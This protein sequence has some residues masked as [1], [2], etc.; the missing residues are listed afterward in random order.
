MR[1]TPRRI[2][3]IPTVR[4]QE[5]RKWTGCLAFFSALAILA[6]ACSDDESAPPEEE[7]C[8]RMEECISPFLQ[9]SVEDCEERIGRCVTVQSPPSREKFE[10]SVRFCLESSDCAG[11]NRCYGDTAICNIAD[12]GPG[13][14]GTGGAAGAG[15]AGGASGG[16]AGGNAG[17][18]ESCTND[19]TRCV[20]EDTINIC[21][22]GAWREHGCDTVCE[23]AFG[24][25]FHSVGCAFDED[26]G[27]DDCRCSE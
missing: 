2:D 9:T 7:V 6:S 21:I 5:M 17:Q 16:G 4:E 25:S 8:A 20:D 14:G 18:G 24:A 27:K 10:S 23:R 3:S 22:N 13:T 15:G 11:F 26:L 19:E 1:F 12:L